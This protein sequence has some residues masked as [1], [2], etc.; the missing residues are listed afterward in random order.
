MGRYL[1]AVVCLNGHMVTD[2]LESAPAVASAHC[3]ECGAKTATRCSHCNEN[4]RGHYQVDGVFTTRRAP[5]RKFCHACGKAYPWTEARLTAAREYADEIDALS[6]DEKEVL[7]KSLDEL[8]KDSP[9]TNV[10]GVRFKKLMAKAGK[11]SAAALRD[12]VVDVVSETAKKAMG[13]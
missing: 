12:I 1:T 4:I 11:E 8:I 5:V 7:K 13:L 3:S 9:Q 6:S 10:A 2:S